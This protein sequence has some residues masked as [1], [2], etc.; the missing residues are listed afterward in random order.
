MLHPTSE[1]QWFEVL[2]LGLDDYKVTLVFR[3]CV[4]S[5]KHNYGTLGNHAFWFDALLLG[6]DSFN[7]HLGHKA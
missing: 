6:L 4:S 3:M 1:V 7:I 2:F 5:L